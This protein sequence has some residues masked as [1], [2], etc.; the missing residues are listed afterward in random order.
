MM[1]DCG[2]RSVE[3]GVQKRFCRQ[4]GFIVTATLVLFFVAAC[5]EKGPV[6]LTIGYE[7]PA[8]KAALTTTVSVGVSPFR[9]D[10]GEPA[11]VLGKRTVPTGM[12]SDFV[13]R[14]TVAETATAI[15]KK[16]FAVRGI[17]VRDIARWDLTAEGMTAAGA[18]LLLGGEIKTLWLESTPSSMQTQMKA[19][20]QI[21][22]TIG[23]RLEKKI[24]RTIDV[25]SK[26]DQEILYSQERLEA[27]LSEALSSAVDQ[28]FLDD[29]LQKRLR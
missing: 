1:E 27:A 24:I 29:V 28:I 4:A 19:S 13:V 11:S 5:A 14:G 17:A 22:I 7:T 3:C 15:L 12:Q 23:D 25:N 8:E 2:M 26:I 20:V 10:R 16:A 9:D 21:K 6:L 18:D